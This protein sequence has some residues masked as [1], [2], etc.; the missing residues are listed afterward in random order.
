M[1]KKWQGALL[2]CVAAAW[3][4]GCGGGKAHKP[5]LVVEEDVSAVIELPDGSRC[6]EPP[7]L[8]ALLASPGGQVAQSR[9]AAEAGTDAKP[10]EA[11]EQKPE[12]K[13]EETA[14]VEPEVKAEDA[15]PR[16]EGE[17]AAAS[18]AEAASS[19]SDEEAAAGD[20]VIGT[21]RVKPD[22][23]AEEATPRNEEEAAAP[24]AAEEKAR[25]AE[26]KPEGATAP[27]AQAE[28]GHLEI[29]AAYFQLCRAYKSNAVDKAEFERQRA[30]YLEL[31]QGL[32]QR[33]IRGWLDRE[34]GIREAG[35]LCMV[36][37]A[38]E[39]PT[40][41]S[42]TRWVPPETSVDDCAVFAAKA[43]AGEILLG[44][45]EGQWQNRW[46]KRAVAVG[47]TGTRNRGLVVS[48]TPSAPDPNCGW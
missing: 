37:H 24:S 3:V 10:A 8:S 34:G 32:L 25:N 41:R 40:A 15:S 35:K 31:R 12:A 48:D 6:T 45:T 38:N 7:G 27:A 16:D 29:E 30:N 28:P 46:A 20:I 21:A 17:V 1:H 44:C 14:P 13:V 22:G 36:V 43:G 4:G 33:G 47:P 39:T 42:F 5:E 2:A 19:R 11:T 9:L 23:D 26:A 18:A